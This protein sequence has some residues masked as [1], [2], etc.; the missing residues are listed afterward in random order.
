MN[1]WLA[2]ASVSFAGRAVDLLVDVSFRSTV[3]LIVAMAAA[4]LVRRQTASVK[5]L[6]WMSAFVLLLAM[7]FLAALAPQ[8]RVLPSWTELVSANHAV[9]TVTGEDGMPAAHVPRVA[10]HASTESGVDLETPTS[11]PPKADFNIISETAMFESPAN[12]GQDTSWEFSHIV[13]LVWLTGASVAMVRLLAAFFSLWHIRRTSETVTDGQLFD[14]FRQLCGELNLR[15]QPRLLRGGEQAMP[16]AWG[17]C[18]FFVMVP[19]KLSDWPKSQRRSVLL[20]ELGH[21]ARRDPMWQMVVEMVRALHWF[22]PL[23]W[24]AISRLQLQRE[25]A[26]DDLVI[27]RGVTPQQY[28]HQLLDVVTRGRLRRVGYAVGVAMASRSRIERRLLSIMDRASSRTPLARWH[29]FASAAICLALGVPLAVIRG[30]DGPDASEPAVAKDAVAKDSEPAPKDT[31]S[32]AKPP[33]AG[34]DDVES[35]RRLAHIGL[36]QRED[37]DAVASVA[38]SRDGRFLYASAYQ[39]A[40]HVVFAR[41]KAT[42]RLEHVQTIQNADL[43][44]GATALRLSHDERFAVAA[45]FRSKA[46][47]LYGRDAKSGKLTL[48]DSKQQD[49][50]EGVMGMEWIIEARFAPDGRF[51]YALDDRGGL[52][53]F[54][55]V[56]MGDAPKLEFADAFRSG[57]LSGARGLVHH[58]SGKYVFVVC[59]T[60]NTLVALRRDA[61]SG[62]LSIAQVVRDEEDGVTG[63]QSAF[64]VNVSRDGDFVYTVSGQHGRGK[65]NS[66]GVFRF[67][68]EKGKLSRVQE[69]LPGKVHLEG[70]RFPFNG[71]NEITVA[72]GQR[73]IYA[74]ATSSG[75]LAA[76]DRDPKTGKVSLIQLISDQE[77][78]G[79][80]S[81]LAV[82]PDGRFV[83]AAAEKL[84]AVSIYGPEGAAK[85]PAAKPPAVPEEVERG[86]RADAVE[87]NQLKLRKIQRDVKVKP[88]LIP[89]PDAKP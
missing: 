33:A 17:V 41:D 23:V 36:V 43:L 38:I 81:G 68:A 34:A 37:L 30:A 15:V 32:D 18:R 65:D 48:L 51:V 52:T 71:G 88:D 1:T 77:S 87:R 59:K 86:L 27:N 49:V 45:A 35:P 56:G 7:P 89:L 21:V 47:S 26:C 79:W 10:S 13:L 73:R 16:M 78:L 25:C 6:V 75:S 5:H 63:L 85:L 28:A 84:D 60:S 9:S 2:S 20:H 72:P 61:M 58:P 44:A 22:N 82:S 4:L 50:D 40:S 74:C 83:Y 11:P 55:L 39:A 12:A 14:E 3:V 70:R 76:F 42:G 19:S 69:I 66:V 24:L 53:S 62:K 57:D 31:A 64:G 67:D 8:W 29:I 54:R 80:V 46:V